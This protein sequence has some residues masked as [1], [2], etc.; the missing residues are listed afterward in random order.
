VI[1][2]RRP[3]GLHRCQNMLPLDP[4]TRDVR[5]P[6]PVP[7][8]FAPGAMM[9]GHGLAR[10]GRRGFG[11][12][13]R[14]RVRWPGC[15]LGCVLALAALVLLLARRDAYGATRSCSP[16]HSS[17]RPAEA[18]PT[19]KR[20][21]ACSSRSP[22]RHGSPGPL[23]PP[24]SASA[25]G[26]WLRLCG[27]SGT[28]SRDDRTTADRWCRGPEARSAVPAMVVIADSGLLTGANGILCALVALVGTSVAYERWR[29]WR[30]RRRPPR[31]GPTDA[32]LVA[33]RMQHRTTRPTDPAAADPDRHEQH[34]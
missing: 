27:A 17:S 19:W 16:L 1:A 4:G 13:H 18:S 7:V 26:W 24:R 11:R 34:G 5:Q 25:R 31:D 2:I 3:R 32:E 28:P 29:R 15:E 12:V 8:R 10:E 9:R 14:S 22:D 6:A 23:W 20:S 33:R 30:D 21:R